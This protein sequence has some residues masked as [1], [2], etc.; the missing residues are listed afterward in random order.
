[1]KVLNLIHKKNFNESRIEYN[2]TR[3][4]E[5]DKT[6]FLK[7]NNSAKNNLK[8]YRVGIDYDEA[9]RSFKN[10][11]QELEDILNNTEYFIKF[12]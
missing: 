12:E 7:I 10:I 4:R 6:P 5:S 3:Y 9:V 1:M 11:I 2:R 8:N